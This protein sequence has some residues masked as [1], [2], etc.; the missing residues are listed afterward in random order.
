[1]EYW[2]EIEIIANN[3]AHLPFSLFFLLLLLGIEICVIP[4]F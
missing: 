1:M 4:V 3:R 2:I